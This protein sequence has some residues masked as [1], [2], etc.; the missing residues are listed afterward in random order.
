MRWP[1]GADGVS[2]LRPAPG[3]LVFLAASDRRSAKAYP[4][5]PV[6][7]NRDDSRMPMYDPSMAMPTW[8]SEFQAFGTVLIGG[9]VAALGFQQYRIAARK[10]KLDLYQR[11]FEIF[12]AMR[13]YL[14]SFMDSE[15]GDAKQISLA[16]YK[17]VAEA[18]FLL[19][20]TA[21]DYL[22]RLMEKILEYKGVREMLQDGL[23]KGARAEEAIK[24]TN[25][26][27]ARMSWFVEQYEPLVREFE[28]FLKLDHALGIGLLSWIKGCHPMGD[29]E[30]PLRR[31]PGSV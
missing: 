12:D 21:C 31:L 11:R 23:L 2:P 3:N 26:Q 14:V 16:A 8:I 24:I 28:R 15:S 1:R 22:D 6:R 9:G 20:D 19:D 7:D 13:R 17:K 30:A 5:E 27:A 4:D 18:R 29:V 10:L 25:E